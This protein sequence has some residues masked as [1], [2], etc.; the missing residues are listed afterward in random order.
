MPFKQSSM[1]HPVSELSTTRQTHRATKA[2]RRRR[3]WMTLAMIVRRHVAFDS[4]WLIS[5]IM[6]LRSSEY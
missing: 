1:L 2:V 3:G 4:D 6:I 5:V